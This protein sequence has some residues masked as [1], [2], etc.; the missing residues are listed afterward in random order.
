MRQALKNINIGPTKFVPKS[1]AEDQTLSETAKD[2]KDRPLVFMV[3][4]LTREDRLNIQGLVE[5][6][7]RKKGGEGKIV[8]INIGT[9][10]RY[11]WENCV[12]EAKNVLLEEDEFESLKGTEKN[13]LFD[14]EG[15]D[16]EIMEA[17]GHVQEISSLA[18]AEVKN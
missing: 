16:L 1:H 11:I 6:D 18:E 7:E 17:V 10:A 3:R 5:T 15:I 12:I 2:I 4:K 8:A 9:V 14:T 13:R